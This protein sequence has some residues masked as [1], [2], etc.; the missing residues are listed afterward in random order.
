[1]KESKSNKKRKIIIKALGTALTMPIFIVLTATTLLYIPSIQKYA[2]NKCSELIARHTNYNLYM[3][4]FNLHLPFHISIGNFTL[5]EAS[6]TLLN[7]DRLRI[8]INIL[9]LI[10]GELVAQ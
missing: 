3:E 2:I 4:K 1:M 7:G 5:S 10:K 8:D 9:P 6:D